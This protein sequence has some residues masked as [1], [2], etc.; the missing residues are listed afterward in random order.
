MNRLVLRRLVVAC[1]AAVALG[2][3]G[4]SSAGSPA[5]AD[6]WSVTVALQQKTTWRYEWERTETTMIGGVPVRC[7]ESE[8]GAGSETLRLATPRAGRV[9]LLIRDDRILV[10]RSVA[11][12]TRGTGTRY[13]ALI[14]STSGPA[15]ACGSSSESAPDEGCGK[16]R[17]TDLLKV[18]GTRD[19]R[20]FGL[21]NAHAGRSPSRCPGPPRGSDVGRSPLRQRNVSW[22]RVQATVGEFLPA[23]KL[24]DPDTKRMVVRLTFRGSVP[25]RGLDRQ[26][27]E[28]T[29]TVVTTVRAKLVFRRL[30]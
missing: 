18:R 25:Y 17:R 4:A 3:A 14:R 1:A 28:Q 9:Q 10:R 13:G 16:K 8:R 2:A 6:E 26:R 29:G 27:P 21:V 7:T 20:H 22:G 24:R 23:S 30:G 15:A 5:L 19:R 12:R 11:I